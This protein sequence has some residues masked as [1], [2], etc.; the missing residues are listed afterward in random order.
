M[1]DRDVLLVAGA[2]AVGKCHFCRWLARKHGYVHLDVDQPAEGRPAQAFAALHACWALGTAETVAAVLTSL[3][4]PVV[5]DWGFPPEQLALVE[6]LKA[7]GAG[8][9]YEAGSA[10]LSVSICP[11]RCSRRARKPAQ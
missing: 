11:A 10:V 1:A 6:R 2:P 7:A 9:R 3:E 5:I 8:V 4:R